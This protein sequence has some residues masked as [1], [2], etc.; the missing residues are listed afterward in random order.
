MKIFDKKVCLVTGGSR[1]IGKA[2][3]R[4]L[5]EEGCS[6]AICGRRQDS[7][8]TAVAS[9]GAGAAGKVAGKAADVRSSEDVR[10]LFQFVDAQ[11]GG[12]DVLVNNAGVGVFRSISDLSIQDWQNTI[13]TNLTGV[14]YCCREALFRFATRGAGYIINIS[15]LAGKNAFA[16]GAAYNASK[17]AL[18]GFSEAVMLDKRN[19]NV[20]VSYV[21]PG[22]VASEFNGRN[23]SDGADWKIWPE[24]IAEIVRTLLCMPARTLISRVEVRPTQPKR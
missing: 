8:D 7:V 2:I 15:S 4:M 6:V 20:R 1:G 5:V 23:A 17:F 12:L 9:L 19:E 10:A 14:F 18:T 24:D 3:A 22:S 11:F 16:G 13:E 21:M